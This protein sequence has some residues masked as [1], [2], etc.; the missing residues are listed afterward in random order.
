MVYNSI[1]LFDKNLFDKAK[2]DKIY[3]CSKIKGSGISFSISALTYKG[4]IVAFV[5]LCLIYITQLNIS[6]SNHSAK[7]DKILVFYS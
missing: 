2:F 7:N 3:I 6:S 1:N 5:F 4:E